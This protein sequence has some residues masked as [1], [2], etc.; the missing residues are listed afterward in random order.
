MSRYNPWRGAILG[1]IGGMSGTL[2]MGYYFKVITKL[3]QNENQGGSDTGTADENQSHALDDISLIGQHYREGESSTVTMGRIIYRTIA[4]Y[5]PKAQETRTTLSELVHWSFGTTMGALYGVIRE[6][7]PPLDLAGGMVFG[8]GVWFF[9]S[10][11]MLPLLGLA[12]G[13]TTEPA[14]QHAQELGAHLVYGAVVATT[15][16]TLAGLLDAG[17]RR[18]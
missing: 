7:T 3:S 8:A 2:A 13:P 1:A 10:E 18:R 9:A 14:V 6:D 16:R 4:G 12:P 5:E 15:T 11:L 17:T